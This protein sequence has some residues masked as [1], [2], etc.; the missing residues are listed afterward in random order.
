MELLSKSLEHAFTLVSAAPRRGRI[1]GQF[2]PVAGA[3]GEGR[4]D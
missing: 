4:A 2:D 3:V 1:D